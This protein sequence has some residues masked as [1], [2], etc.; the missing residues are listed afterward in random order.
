M[1]DNTP[2]YSQPQ[3]PSYPQTPSSY[4]GAPVPTVMQ[5]PG[6]SGH[7]ALSKGTMALLVSL[8]LLVMLGGVGLILYAGVVHPAQLR[9]QSVQTASAY[10]TVTARAQAT[11]F[12]AA[13]ATVQRQAQ[14]TAT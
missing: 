2:P 7:A 1:R 3:S 6:Q 14:A 13:T 9:V 4:Y 11:S 8:A 10:V 12:A 5:Q